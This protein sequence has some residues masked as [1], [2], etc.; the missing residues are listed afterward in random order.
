MLILRGLRKQIA[1]P[2]GGAIEELSN[3]I[4]KLN[5]PGG[6]FSSIDPFYI[7]TLIPEIA[8]RCCN[9]IRGANW[10]KSEDMIAILMNEP[11]SS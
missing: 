7:C 3:S 2:I 11:I 1:R 6:M 4:S 9:D 10:D 5:M 8:F